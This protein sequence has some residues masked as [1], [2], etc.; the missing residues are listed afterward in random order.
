MSGKEKIRDPQDL[1][2]ELVSRELA[3]DAD[4]MAALYD[5][6]AVL[7]TGNG[8]EAVGRDAIRFFYAGLIA[9]GRK[10]E[11][12]EQRPAVVKG[13]LALTSTRLPNGTVTAEIAQKQA[14]GTW[15][16]IIDQP[17]IA[18]E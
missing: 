13:D 9:A 6:S 16:W 3:G 1:A 17:S 8:R 15:L 4:A 10:F 18:K 5:S 14:D 12:G 7:Y 11:L 2:R